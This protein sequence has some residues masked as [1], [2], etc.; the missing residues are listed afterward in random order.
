MTTESHTHHFASP[1]Y[2]GSTAS[3]PTPA[4]DCGITAELEI[5]YLVTANGITIGKDGWVYVAQAMGSEVSRVHPETGEVQLYAR[6]DCGINGP[7]DV[8][9]DTKGNL[10]VTE[11]FVGRVGV[12]RPDGT[13]ETVGEGFPSAN[14]IATHGDRLFVNEYREGG[15]LYEVDPTTGDRRAIALNLSWPN[16][17]SI[18]PEEV[19]YY[20]AVHVGEIWQVNLDGSDHRRIVDGLNVPTAVKYGPDGQIYTTEHGGR[21]LRIDPATGAVDHIATLTPG[22]D[23]LVFTDTGHLIASNSVEAV[24]TEI[25]L[26]THK[27]RQILQ[28]GLTGPF[29]IASKDGD[30]YVV[31]D[32]FSYLVVE[33]DGSSR[34]P[35]TDSTPGFPGVLRGVESMP[36]SDD[37]VFTS[38]SGTVS[39][40]NP[41]SGNRI[42]AEGLATP[43]GI[44]ARES[45]FAVAEYGAGQLVIIDDSADPIV[46]ATDLVRP[47][48]VTDMDGKAWLVTESGRGAVTA[49]SSDGVSRTLIEGLAEPHGV[50]WHDECIYV[51]ERG[52]RRLTRWSQDG[53]LL[54]VIVEGLPVGPAGGVVMPELPGIPPIAPGPWPPFSDMTVLDSGDILITSDQLGTVLKVSRHSVS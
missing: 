20:P 2:G 21:V 4:T 48:A 9:F 35:A 25:D 39:R 32:P 33:K 44:A 41:D 52:A 27:T 6:A 5:S 53:S 31:T 1:R 19:L 49:I 46:L 16:G 13:Y 24:L 8:A 26:T 18:S 15:G 3:P 14:G 28:P 12:V 51:V 36:N 30:S 54:G 11:L 50:A 45:V 38:M 22:L 47:I 34:R 43:M 17:M 40:F 10:Y 23:N 37:F 29:G 42:L 7:D